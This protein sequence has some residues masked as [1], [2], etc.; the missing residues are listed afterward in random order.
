MI[1]FAGRGDALEVAIA[2]G[3][4]FSSAFSGN[5]VQI[6]PVGAL[7]STPYRF[8]ARPWDLDQVESTCTTC[9]VGC[10]AAVQS[11]ANRVTRLL[12]MDSDP[13]NQ[14]WL[15]DKGRYGYEAVN[16]DNRLT[17]PLVRSAGGVLEPAT[18]SQALSRSP[19]PGLL[20][21]RRRTGA[22]FDRR[23]RR[24]PSHER[25]CLRVGEARKGCYRHRLGRRADRRRLAGGARA[26]AASSDDR[27]SMLREVCRRPR[28]GP[29]R[30]AAGAVPPAA[31]GGGGF[32][33]PI[34]EMTPRART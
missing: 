27:R 31:R 29:L 18:W 10:R 25:G 7:T 14:S 15:C 8:T 11:S 26:R 28:R 34:V 4:V 13:V 16:S 5:T 17:E 32:G 12:G 22:G 6:C 3:H 33:L 2:D 20:R 23:D 1:D 9:A 24:R 19:A 21:S 30:G